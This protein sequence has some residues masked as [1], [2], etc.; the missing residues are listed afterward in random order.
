MGAACGASVEGL[1]GVGGGAAAAQAACRERARC[2][3]SLA[4]EG[5]RGAHVKHVRHARDAG[6]VEAHRLVERRRELPRGKRGGRGEKGATCGAGGG[7]EGR[8]GGGGGASRVQ[9]V[10][11]LRR[12]AGQ[13]VAR[14]ERT[15]NMEFMLV[16]LD[17]SKLSGW[18]NADARCRGARGG[19]RERGAACGAGG[20]QEGVG[21]RRAAQAACGERASCGG[22]LARGHAR[23]APQTWRSCS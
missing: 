16:T 20:R 4:R 1:G 11:Q 18:L 10:S 7:A 8:G 6:R 2:R 3:G 15:L 22:S 5:T 21:G 19:R 12:V 9:G 23:S 17:V 14:A 13:G